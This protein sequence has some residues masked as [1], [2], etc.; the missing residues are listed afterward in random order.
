MQDRF[1]AIIAK[2]ALYGA[3]S[4]SARTKHLVTGYGKREWINGEIL[5]FVTVERFKW[6]NDDFGY[7][8]TIHQSAY[9]YPR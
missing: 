1:S 2:R 7:Y 6:Y 4:Y 5:H 3:Y 9:K 8:E